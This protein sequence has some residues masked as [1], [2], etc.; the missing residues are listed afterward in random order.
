MR[1]TLFWKS[2]WY[3]VV[4]LPKYTALPSF[5]QLLFVISPL[6][7]FLMCPQHSFLPS[8][9][10][11]CRFYTAALLLTPPPPPVN[12]LVS[13]PS[14]QCSALAPR[15]TPF[16]HVPFAYPP[17]CTLHMLLSPNC[18]QNRT[19]CVLTFLLMFHLATPLFLCFVAIYSFSYY[20]SIP[21]AIPAKLI[22]PTP[23]YWNTT[24]QVKRK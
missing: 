21:D 20:F 1:S 13:Y 3:M 4:A 2:I 22:N 16:I 9:S 11:P 17:W 7:F 18:L 5:S 8:S 15:N 23:G 14:L 24:Q 12:P 19:A 6:R 10:L